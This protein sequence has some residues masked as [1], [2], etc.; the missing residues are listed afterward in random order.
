LG[1]DF[2]SAWSHKSHLSWQDQSSNHTPQFHELFHQSYPQFYEQAAPQQ[3][4]QAE[5]LLPKS[6]HFKQN[7]LAILI[8]LE[9]SKQLLQSIDAKIETQEKASPIYWPQQYKEEPPPPKSYDISSL[10]SKFEADNQLLQSIVKIV[11]H[12][13][14]PPPIRETISFHG[15]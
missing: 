15:F 14:E 8:Q 6:S 12:E 10:F 3:Q 1:N 11:A 4:Y 7:V 5:P 13:E 2:Y 9:A